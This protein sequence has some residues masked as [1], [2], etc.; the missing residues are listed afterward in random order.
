MPTLFVSK[1]INAHTWYFYYIFAFRRPRKRT[2]SY[3]SFWIR[4]FCHPFHNVF[5]KIG[6]VL[7][8][9]TTF[10][11]IDM[12]IRGM[13]WEL[14][15]CG[16]KSSNIMYVQCP[17]YCMYIIFDLFLYGCVRETLFLASPEEKTEGMS[18]FLLRRKYFLRHSQ[19]LNSIVCFH[20]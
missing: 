9:T 2:L 10:L 17:L 8:R 14:K 18:I 15:N 3:N 5:T 4:P 6:L 7:Y 11:L 12:V 13:F 1:N 20:I 16:G 19:L